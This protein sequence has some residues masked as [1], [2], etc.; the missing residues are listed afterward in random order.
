VQLL[1][2]GSAPRQVRVADFDVDGRP[3]LVVTVQDGVKILRNRSTPAGIEFEV[4][5]ASNGVFGGG[6]G[7][8]GA[9]VA[10]LDR[11]GRLDLAIADFDSGDLQ[12]LRGGSSPFDFSAPPQFVPLGGAPVDVAAADFDG[13]GIVDLAVSRNALSDIVLLVNDGHGALTLQASIAVGAAPNVLLTGDL[14]RDG[15]GD[16]VVANGDGDSVTVLFG[17]AA[18]FTSRS[19]AAGDLPTALAVDDLTGDGL[20]DVLV[21]GRFGEDFRV[22]VND[23]VGGFANVFPFP[24]TRGS[25]AVALADFDRDGDRDLVLASVLQDRISV[26]RS[27]AVP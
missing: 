8:Y 2:I 1:D 26:V 18:G 20:L 22:L 6:Q 25:S 5:P 15:R 21:A 24:G 13:D 17:G 9:A 11:D 3:D 12:I 7:P 23:G 27:L 16:L 19:Y 4:L 10:D 14:D